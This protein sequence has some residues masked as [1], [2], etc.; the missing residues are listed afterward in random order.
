L[1][2]SVLLRT[3]DF[4]QRS[5]SSSSALPGRRL[6]IVPSETVREIELDELCREM[7]PPTDDEVPTALDGTRL[8]TKEKLIAH[9][10]RINNH[11]DQLRVR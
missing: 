5:A 2:V 3:F 10:E 11:R 8:D 7:G 9:L 1:V 4:G 6:S